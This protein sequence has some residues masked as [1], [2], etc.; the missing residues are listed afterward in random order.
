MYVVELGCW[1]VARRWPRG[2]ALEGAVVFGAGAPKV[3]TGLYLRRSIHT[4]DAC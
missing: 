1:E 3:N 2:G 4:A